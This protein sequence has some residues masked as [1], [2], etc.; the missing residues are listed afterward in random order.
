MNKPTALKSVTLI[1]KC[2]AS[3]EYDGD[4]PELV[5]I[6]ITPNM[7][8]TIE[9]YL[10]AIADMKSNGLNPSTISTHD[11]PCIQFIASGLDGLNP[12]NPDEYIQLMFASDDVECTFN[13]IFVVD[14]NP[15]E[16]STMDSL[17]Y[18]ERTECAKLKI[19]HD[20][21]IWVDALEKYTGTLF[22]SEGFG[23]T[24]LNEVKKKLGIVCWGRY[25][26]VILTSGVC[27]IN[28]Q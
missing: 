13:E 20:S 24:T 15:D 26:F 1:T 5:A 6:T 2:I 23:L 19:R 17:Q 14:S 27:I 10:K 3:S 11:T 25:S 16:Y 12:L 21:L 8:N 7:V 9:R 22:E 18:S 4:R 28:Q